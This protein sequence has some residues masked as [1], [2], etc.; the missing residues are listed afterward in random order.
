M[1]RFTYVISTLSDRVSFSIYV[2]ADPTAPPAVQF[3]L[4]V[5]EAEAM[6]KQLL[7]NIA[8]VRAAGP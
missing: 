7:A 6:A 5:D 1:S 2:D 3:N 4:E 8:K